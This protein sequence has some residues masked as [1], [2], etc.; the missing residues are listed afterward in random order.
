MGNYPIHTLSQLSPIL[1]GFRKTHHLTQKAVA[2]Q[3]GITQQ[4]Y[5]ELEANPASASVER[6]FRVLRVLNVELLLGEGPQHT[7][8]AP[9]P[10]DA[11]DKP[12]PH[13]KESW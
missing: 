2:Q 7:V 13:K 5:A 8:Q 11:V 6:L 1:K 3:L 4:S 10:S 12:S 9:A